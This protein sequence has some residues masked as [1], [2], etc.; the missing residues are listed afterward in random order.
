MNENKQFIIPKEIYEPK[1]LFNK[2]TVLF[3]TSPIGSNPSTAIIDEVFDGCLN[4]KNLEY[5]KK[6]IMYVLIYIYL[7]ITFIFLKLLFFFY[8]FKG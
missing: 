1:Y 8:Y 3:T 2:I 5:C 6:I 7:I 4:V